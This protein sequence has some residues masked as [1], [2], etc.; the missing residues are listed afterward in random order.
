MRWNRLWIL[1]CGTLFI[2]TLFVQATPDKPSKPKHYPDSPLRTIVI[3]AGH[4]GTDVGARGS[5]STEKEI[6]LDVALKLGKLLEEN[7]P[8]VKVVYTRKVDRFDDPRRK[9]QIANDA[10]G[11]LFISIHC[12][13]AP[14]T[15]HVTGHRTVYRRKGKRKVAVR[16]P[17]YSY[18]PSTA[19]GTE[20]YVW[21][22][23]KNDA[24]TESLKASSVMVLDGNSE[25]AKEV[26]DAA[27]PET[28]ILLNTLRNAFFDQSLR[29][30]SMVEDEFTKVGRISRGARQ[31][32]EK[33][34]WVLQAT[35]MPSVLVE[36]GFISNPDEEK[37]LNSADGQN[38]T[39][40]CIY[41]AVKRYKE[42]LERFGNK[43][44]QAAPAPPPPV[45]QPVVQ[46]VIETGY[47]QPAK[48][49]AAG[50]AAS[51]TL[52]R[53][54]LL[55]SEKKYSAQSPIFKQLGPPI[56]KEPVIINRKKVN[57]Y[58]WGSFRTEAEA[59]AALRKAKRIGF[60]D[61]FIVPYKN[62]L[63]LEAQM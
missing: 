63:R 59:D 44:P 57:K 31:R 54:Q 22:T 11:D 46:P 45:P 23:S 34:I 49:S 27:D 8:D 33:G 39:A 55:V 24:K 20:T 3:D 7:M 38:E 6:T 10:H 61:A 56:Q 30:S 28:F 29:L 25:E 12:N 48:T 37:Y 42:E 50:T 14:K 16:V 5:Y 40:M 18:S 62:G 9:A 41:K 36:L 2:F 60:K 52:Y 35:A 43:E 15:R 26:M 13:S 32:N 47:K 19:Q 51:S 17:I 21:A 53:V 1:G 58:I 4:G